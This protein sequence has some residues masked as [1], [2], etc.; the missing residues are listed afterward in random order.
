MRDFSTLLGGVSVKDFAQSRGISK[1]TVY[2]RLNNGITNIED[3]GRVTPPWPVLTEED[4]AL[5][6][7]YST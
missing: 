3:L 7:S 1:A 4:L 2:Y 5:L 6:R